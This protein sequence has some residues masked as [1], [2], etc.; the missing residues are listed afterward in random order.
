MTFT[1]YTD[2]SCDNHW[3]RLTDKEYKKSTSTNLK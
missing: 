2:G 3:H 1:A